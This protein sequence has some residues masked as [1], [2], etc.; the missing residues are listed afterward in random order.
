MRSVAVRAGVSPTAAGRALARLEDQQLV[1][2][3]RTWVAAGRAQEVELLHA[4]IASPDWPALAP[5]LATV[6]P[7]VVNGGKKLGGRV[8]PRLRHLF[9]NTDPAQLDVERGGDYIARRLIQAG[10]L[11]GLAWGAEHLRAEHWYRAAATRGL[12]DRM[13]SLARNLAESHAQQ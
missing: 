2:R 10:D 8:P 6:E 11:E 4:N 12:T 9:W 7:P 1:R 5:R 13:R 3:E